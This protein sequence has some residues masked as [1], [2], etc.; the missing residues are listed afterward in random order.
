MT[1]T[2]KRLALLLV[3]VAAGPALLQAET[4]DVAGRARTYEIHR[5]A[6]RDPAKPAALVIMLHGG[7]G[8]GRQAERAYGWDA[9]ADR[10]GFVVAYPDGIGR[11]WNAGGTC[12]GPARRDAVDD[13]GFITALIAAVTRRETI[14]PA[15]VYLTGMSNGAAMAY[16][17][18]C[19]G[20]FPVAAIGPVAGS[21]AFACTP[22]RP[23]SVMA[24]HGLDD[25][26]IP[27]GGGVG[28][29]GVSGVAWRPVA[30]TIDA[31][32]RAD[33]CEPATP[34]QKG[35]V[36][37]ATSRCAGGREVVLTTVA[38]A[39][40]QWPSSARGGLLVRLFLDAPSGA[41]DAT[42]A[43]A[44]FFARHRAD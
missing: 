8:T 43:L 44:D 30:E 10:A 27:I 2:A 33:R 34:G 26:N 19:E 4:L 28:S 12:C 29:K 22:R 40:H 13:L 37:T 9:A 23:V 7:F 15:R 31:F 24:I 16:R 41:L 6:G 35:G 11:S 3:S 39:G 38:G 21:L 17:Y 32:R 42:A 20:E 5:P 18:A 14:D 25:G 36:T 1:C